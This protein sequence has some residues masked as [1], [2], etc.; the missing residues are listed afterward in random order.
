MSLMPS[1]LSRNVP[2]AT[3]LF[4]ACSARLSA[5]M[6]LPL[7]M[8]ARYSLFE[9]TVATEAPTPTLPPTAPAQA[10]AP[11][12]LV[13]CACRRMSPALSIC[14][15][16]PMV[17]AVCAFDTATAN[18][19]ATPTL[20]PPA[21]AMPSAVSRLA[22]A[23][24]RFCV[25][26]AVTLMSCAPVIWV[27]SP[28]CAEVLLLETAMPTPTPTPALLAALTASPAPRARK[29]LSWLA[30]TSIAPPVASWWPPATEASTLSAI[31]ATPTAAAIATLP[32]PWVAWLVCASWLPSSALVLAALWDCPLYRSYISLASDPPA[33]ALASET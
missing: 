1:T 14:V 28:S 9:T 25:D 5:L 23:A 30:R 24:S 4:C 33:L 2:G 27:W 11:S 26:S 18:A 31:T 17:A 7:P 16:A 15:W 12:M 13:L 29:L 3:W 20:L 21:P 10:L 19:P 22:K 32:P 6:S 8:L